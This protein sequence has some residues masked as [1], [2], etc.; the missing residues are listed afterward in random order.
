MQESDIDNIANKLFVDRTARFSW[1]V[2]PGYNRETLMVRC[3]PYRNPEGKWSARS[4]IIVGI[5]R[6]N[7]ITLAMTEFDPDDRTIWEEYFGQPRSEGLTPEEITALM[8]LTSGIRTRLTEMLTAEQLSQDIIRQ[9][10]AAKA[11]EDARAIVSASTSNASS[12]PFI[13]TLP[14]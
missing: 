11:S 12:A 4:D 7:M 3:A 2:R 8:L 10:V 6:V 9:V 1:S 5:R 14:E 13:L